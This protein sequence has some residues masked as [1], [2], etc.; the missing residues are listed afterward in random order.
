MDQLL[1][2][3]IPT[4]RIGSDGFNWW[5]GQVE[6][7]AAEEKTNKGGYRFKVRIVGDH[8]ASKEILDT[9]D[10]PW[11]NVMMPVNVPFMPGNVGGAHP[12]LIKG[13]WVVGFYLD[14]LKQKPIIMGSI[15]QTPGAT[16]ISKSERPDGSTAFGTVNNTVD[17]PVNPVTDGQPAPENP[18]GGQGEANKTTGALPTGDDTVPIPPRMLK[19]RDDE[20]WCQSVA[21]KCDKQNLTDKT[22][23][24]LGEFLN[25]VQKN[26]GNIGTYLIS[27][28]SGTI[29]SGVGIARK[30]V[31]KFMAVIRHFIA[32]V[33]GFVLEKLTNAVKDLIKAV[34]YPNETGNALTPV[35]EWFNNLL[36][37]LGCKMADLGDRL[38][39]WLTNVLMGLVNQVYR[40]AACQVDT[41]VNGILSK[42][43][44][45]MET[46]LS[47]IL[48]PIQDILG[49]I[50]GPLNILGG[51]INF[52]LKLLGI[53][54][55]GPNNEC[56]G[57]K[58]ICTDGEKK[59]KE[60]KKGNDFLDD[61]LSNIDNLFPATG[62]D[63][64]QYTCEDAYTGKP[65]SITTVGFTGGVPRY[66]DK[67]TKSP[68]I[69]YTI[70]DIVV[71]EGFDAVFQV[72]RT[73]VT[74][75]ASSV[76]YRTSK[77][78]TATPDK[79][80]L[81]DNGILGFAPGET[82]KNITIRTF[83][84]PENE[85]D[86]DFYVILKKNSPGEGSRIRSTFI[87]NVGRCVITERNVK[88]PGT[89][90][91]PK[92]INPITELP[93]V[94]PPD[95]IEDI[96]TPPSDDTP[97]P[98]DDTSPSYEV[99]ADKVSVNEGDFVQYTITTEN[100]ENGTYAYYT[101]TGDIDSSDIIGGAT[102]GSFVVNNNTAEVIVGIS[103]DSLDEEEELLIFTVNGTG[104]TTDV[105][106]VPLTEEISTEPPEDDGE[107]DTP[108]TTTDEFIVPEVIPET[109]ITDDN[110]GIIEIPISQPGDPWAEPP[111]V[112]IGG[113]GIGAVATPLLDQDG[114]ITEIRIKA[115]GYGYKL[116]LA[117]ESGVR[118]IIDA[119]TIIRPG[120]GY[121]SEPDMY[122]NGELGVAEAIINEDGFVVGARIL[123]RQLTF[124]KFPEIVIVGGGGYGAKLLPSFRCL[125]TE[126][127]TTVGSTKIG[128]GRY[129]DCP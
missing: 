36:K 17:N 21:E 63:F 68:K 94:F 110:G 13:C 16:T 66:S 95:V 64:N 124:E 47:S 19:G 18:E 59:D 123:D 81:P 71:E 70:S 100:V 30:Y 74:E 98:S 11:A 54:C 78:G 120:I 60:D 129:I 3:L 4:Q 102:T 10:L 128:T 80:Y 46:I 43:N 89:P 87:K 122:I 2:Q 65:L 85:S 35:T 83:S 32:K 23:I 111:Y 101:L 6:Q 52:V 41:L 69:V 1:S 9:P 77:K 31:N 90:Y 84:S 51:A 29:N 5:V 53:S 34:L 38:A 125:D 67:P 109:I 62:A 8:P 92:P 58:Q 48:G 118:C 117:N 14:H 86:E 27:P 45:L 40:A 39:E 112:F 55:S 15:G 79:D 91:Y 24:L 7:T 99:V 82:V 22:K 96:P 28:I 76:S 103:E 116:N 104:A 49:A 126:A 50:A 26:D 72:T 25:E 105:L 73:G 115:P 107:G 57:Y 33:K 20:K 106:V 97:P 108:D 113:E 114:F 37:D 56:A 119:F 121:T 93:D 12:Q 42:I 44:S 88:E 75:S 127:L 61:L